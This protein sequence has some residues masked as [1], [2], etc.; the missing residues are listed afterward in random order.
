[1]QFESRTIKDLGEL[2]GDVLVFGGPYSNF[3][4]TEALLNHAAVFEIPP[5]H[6]ICTGDAVAYCAN[7]MET[8]N[9]L[10]EQ[11]EWL[12]GN[13]EKQLATKS[14][15]CGCGFEVGS[16]CDLLSR[17]WYP[18]ASSSI[19]NKQR[20]MMSR[21]PDVII[22]R[23]NDLSVAVIHGGFTDISR[24]IWS[25]TDDDIFINEINA[26]TAEVGPVDLILAGHSGIGFQ[27]QIG[28]VQ[29]INAGVIGMPANDGNPTTQYLVLTETGPVFETLRY[30]HQAAS[31]A[32]VDAGLTQGYEIALK[33][34]YWPS[35]DVLPLEMRR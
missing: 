2:S 21:C 33:T 11:C 28:A 17:G 8:L 14:D 16:A 7:P 3:Q 9:L 22:F 31:V 30:D 20:Q 35:Q 18:Y 27:R 6:R 25:V 19:D 13:C 4:A 1:M 15:D 26:L 29:W 12:A 24:F 32:M 5:T 34:G 23:H 10:N